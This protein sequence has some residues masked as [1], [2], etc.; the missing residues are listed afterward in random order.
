M[1]AVEILRS[2]QRAKNFGHRNRTPAH[3]GP[4]HRNRTPAQQTERMNLMQQ[5][6]SVS[7]DLI[8][9]IAIFGV[10]VIHTC[11]LGYQN[12][13]LSANWLASVF[14]GCITRASV[15]LFFMCS[16]ALLLNPEKSLSLK[17]LYTRNFPRIALALFFWALCYKA[18]H[19]II[20]DSL[21]TAA[22]LQ[23]VKDLLLFRHEYHL[24]FLHILMLVYVLLPIVRVFTCHAS[25]TELRYALILW[26][27]LGIVYP[28]LRPYWP[29]SLL[30]G[31]PSQWMLNMTYAAVGYGLLGFYI[32]RY[33]ILANRGG[34]FNGSFWLAALPCSSL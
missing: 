18:Y 20:S 8:K 14:W 24:Y 29:L 3:I 7:I 33:G 17:K 30:G 1:A 19:L 27:C 23:T 2:E 16:G 25:R 10:V 6:R 12:P 21:N 9:A 32:C 13:L 11:S 28:T 34:A 26:F 15:P 5:K 4:G 22:L 31:I